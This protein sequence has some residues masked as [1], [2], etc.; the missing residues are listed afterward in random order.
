MVGRAPP[1]AVAARV[2]CVHH[3][4]AP[5]ARSGPAAA[6]GSGWPSLRWGGGEGLVQRGGVEFE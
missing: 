5:P 4:P 2:G 6:T 3:G 1:R